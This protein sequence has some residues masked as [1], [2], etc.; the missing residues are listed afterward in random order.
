M[1]NEEN[2]VKIESY[3]QLKETADGKQKVLFHVKS[4]E[5]PMIATFYSTDDPGCDRRS[6]KC[7]IFTTIDGESIKCSNVDILNDG[8]LVINNAATRL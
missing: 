2:V 5:E 7:Y 1:K 6:S 8:S 4:N 3:Q